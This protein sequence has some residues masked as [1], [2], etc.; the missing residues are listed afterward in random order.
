MK[1]CSNWV[2]HRTL[3][4]FAR[5]HKRMKT[6][7]PHEDFPHLPGRECLPGT[8]GTKYT[9][10]KLLGRVE[11]NEWS[12]SLP[13]SERLERYMAT[14]LAIPGLPTSGLLSLFL[15]KNKELTALG[16]FCVA[17]SFGKTGASD[18]GADC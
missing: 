17:C 9:I 12:D 7:Y 11:S 18:A 16:A 8:H 4:Q 2:V 6:Q 1:L 13:L 10:G 14:I 5:F 15:K 3:E